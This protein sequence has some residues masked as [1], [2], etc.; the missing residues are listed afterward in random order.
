MENVWYFSTFYIPSDMTFIIQTAVGCDHLKETMS[1]N[2]KKM[3]VKEILW[4]RTEK[5]NE[6]D[7]SSV[8][9]IFFTAWVEVIIETA[10]LSFYLYYEQFATKVTERMQAT[11]EGISDSV[12]S[13][14]SSFF[15]AAVNSMKYAGMY[16]TQKEA[17]WGKYSEDQNKTTSQRGYL[18]PLIS[19]DNRKSTLHESTLDARNKGDSAESVHHAFIHHNLSLQDS[20]KGIDPMIVRKM[21]QAIEADLWKNNIGWQYLNNLLVNVVEVFSNQLR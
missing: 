14:V 6:N 3:V 20:L 7:G 13:L 2:F 19:M 21:L 12:F 11:F 17:E 5:K 4:D 10:S 8:F 16:V 1:D 15:S 9:D 18:F